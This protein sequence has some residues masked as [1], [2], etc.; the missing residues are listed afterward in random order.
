VSGIYRRAACG[1]LSGCLLTNS[2]PESLNNEAISASVRC[3]LD[4]K[5]FVSSD[6][7]T[8]GKMIIRIKEVSRPAKSSLM[9]LATPDLLV[10]F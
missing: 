5:L 8:T 3:Y 4:A 1:G 7:E 2:G 9:I 6:D 10:I